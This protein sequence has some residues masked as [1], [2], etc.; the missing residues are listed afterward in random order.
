MFLQVQYRAVEKL[1]AKD[2]VPGEYSTLHVNDTQLQ[3]NASDFMHVITNLEP[4]TLYE[5][6]VTSYIPTQ[7]GETSGSENIMV[8][9]RGSSGKVV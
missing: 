2:F 1:Y 5:F 8:Y 9:T 4:A 7:S 3:T 6:R